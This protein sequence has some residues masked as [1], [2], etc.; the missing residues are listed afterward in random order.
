MDAEWS[1]RYDK[2]DL[3]EKTRRCDG[4]R[5]IQANNV[6][7]RKGAW[8]RTEI[9]VIDP[10]SPI[11]RRWGPESERA[12]ALQLRLHS[13]PWSPPRRPL[14]DDSLLS[15]P[16]HASSL[17]CEQIGLEAMKRKLPVEAVWC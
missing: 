15:T 5:R 4:L 16:T 11:F 7:N 13:L 8:R 6:L 3:N 9:P 2:R 12:L 17:D 10:G 14:H 1:Y